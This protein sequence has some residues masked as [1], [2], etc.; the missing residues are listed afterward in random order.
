MEPPER[1]EKQ[2]RQRGL[3]LVDGSYM[4]N[5]R[6]SVEPGFRFS[7]LRLRQYLE[8]SGPIWRA[9][10]LDSF[11]PNRPQDLGFRHWL[12]KAPPEG[13]QLIV[14]DYPLRRTHVERAYCESCGE[15]VEPSCPHGPGHSLHKEHQKGVDV[16]LATLALTLMDHYDSLIL[17]SGDSDLL[18]VVEHLIHRGKR[19]ELAVFKHGVAVELQSRADAVHWLDDFAGEVSS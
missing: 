3:W 2:L 4:F 17:S 7:Y 19:M 1:E 18:D 5:A 13:P 9:Y 12:Q 10:Y 15:I 8:R 14:K 16:G 11:D 6:I